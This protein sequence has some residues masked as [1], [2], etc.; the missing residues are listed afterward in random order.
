MSKNPKWKVKIKTI[1]Q[2]SDIDHETPK[3]VFKQVKE[4]HTILRKLNHNDKCVT[5][6]RNY[7]RGLIH[8]SRKYLA[9]YASSY[10]EV[11][12][13]LGKNSY[14]AHFPTWPNKDDLKVFFNDTL[15]QLRFERKRNKQPMRQDTKEY[16]GISYKTVGG[17]FEKNY[18]S[19]IIQD[20]NNNA[21]NR[22]SRTK[23][24]HRRITSKYVGIELEFLS[25][26]GL[27]TLQTLMC[28]AR[29][30][31]YVHVGTDGSVTDPKG[32]A[33]GMEVR[34]L[35]K[36][37]DVQDIVSRTC[38]VIKENTGFVNNTCGMHVHFDMR[39]RDYKKSF[40][41]MVM[42]LPLLSSMVP[43]TRTDTW[44][45]RYCK[46]NKQPNFDKAI[47][48]HDRYQ[49][50][51]AESYGRHQTIEVRLHSGSLNASKICNWIKV[52]IPLVDCESM[53]QTPINKVEDYCKHFEV[54]EKLVNYMK[55]R[56][57]LFSKTL[58]TEEDEKTYNNYEIAI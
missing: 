19:K 34:I 38:K 36:E 18:L 47:S 11:T 9:D 39:T 13:T 10:Y 50:I 2:A 52:I 17:V 28:E 6:E 51:N 55:S 16:M 33:R 37:E 57:E 14:V 23:K 22:I 25:K 24:P 29:L 48:E 7:L 30:E 35:C 3:K 53:I 5:L 40:H 49:A 12:A 27:D 31:G 41:N 1:T 26:A 42:G 44:G 8:E 58:S 20:K 46:L 21:L 4:L 15:N 56:V 43:S 32:E 45:Q 54:S